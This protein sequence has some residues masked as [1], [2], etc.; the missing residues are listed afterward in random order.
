[1]STRSFQ[2][3]AFIA[4]AAL[5]IGGCASSQMRPENAQAAPPPSTDT[6]IG[7]TGTPAGSSRIGEIIER[8]TFRVGT[9]GTQPPFSVMSRSGELIGYEIDL[10]KLLADAMGVKLELVQKPFAEL[11]PA[12]HEGEVDAVMSGMTMTPKRNTKVAFVGPYIVS[13]KSILTKSSSP[14]ASADNTEDIDQSKVTLAALKESTSQT[15]CERVLPKASLTTVDDYAAGV[16]L[17]LKDKVHAMVA[18]FPICILSILRHPDAGLVTLDQPLTIEPIG[19]ALAPGDPLLINMVE[20]YLSALKAVGLLD[21]L[22]EKW[23]EDG[24]WLRQMP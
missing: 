9:S 14:L 17:V 22:Q 10:A 4:A 16:T 18:D 19:T 8:G 2:V 20:N 12:L 5:L 7:S 1:M 24:S 13:G 11:L 3:Y 15:F 23:F 6:T 21:A